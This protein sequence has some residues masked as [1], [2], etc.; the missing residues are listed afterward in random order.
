LAVVTIVRIGMAIAA[1]FVLRDKRVLRDLWFI[2]LRD[3][4]AVVI[5][6]GAY[7]SNTVDWRGQRFVL[8]K[9]KL[10]SIDL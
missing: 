4:L 3:V 1:A 6:A 9:G 5:W 7:L 8:K 10:A 2:P